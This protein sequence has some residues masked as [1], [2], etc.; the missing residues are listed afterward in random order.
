MGLLVHP[1]YSAPSPEVGS[2]QEFAERSQDRPIRGR[3]LAPGSADP[4]ELFRDQRPL[5]LID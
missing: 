5:C 2:V 4:S 3:K 1:E